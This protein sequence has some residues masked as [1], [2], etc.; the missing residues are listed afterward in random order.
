MVRVKNNE[1][2][3]YVVPLRSEW[4][5]VP[6]WRRSK[7]AVDGLRSFII[8]HTKVKN[9]RI[10]KLVNEQIWSRG[11]KNPPHKIE[12]N[13][14]ISTEKIQD[15]KTKKE[16]DVPFVEVELTQIS[17]RAERLEKKKEDRL[18]KFKKSESPK[19][20]K[21]EKSEDKESFKEKVKKKIA[22][23]EEPKEHKKSTKEL[24]EELHKAEEEKKKETKKEAKVTKAQEM[25]MKH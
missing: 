25:S 23:K 10:S 22:K 14:K 9:V 3:K 11:G 4:L 5:Q 7:R 20:K 12:V 18:K 21:E 8:K 2:R 16:V 24:A 17:K 15:K 6:R 19:E 13:A 1:T